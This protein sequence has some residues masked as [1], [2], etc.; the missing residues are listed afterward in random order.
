MVKLIQD[1]Q[2]NNLPTISNSFYPNPVWRTM[3]S[4]DYQQYYDKKKGIRSFQQARNK[5]KCKPDE[6]FKLDYTTKRFYN[7]TDYKTRNNV[8][9]YY[10]LIHPYC[11]LDSENP[12]ISATGTQ[13]YNNT[14]AKEGIVG[15]LSTT[16]Y[17]PGI[18]TPLQPTTLNEI[19]GGIPFNQCSNFK[20]GFGKNSIYTFRF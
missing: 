7:F 16:P 14:I 10:H 17:V 20:N 5:N 13:L 3:D 9:K 6:N 4:F 19:K 12:T 11:E 2:Q 1:I 15:R 18:D 8:S